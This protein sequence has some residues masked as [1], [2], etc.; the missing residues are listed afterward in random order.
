MPRWGSK[1]Q[2]EEP[3]KQSPTV[4][5]LR[6]AWDGKLYTE[7]Q[8]KEHYGG[9]GGADIWK[10]QEPTA[11]FTSSPRW[12]HNEG[13]DTPALVP[14]TS[15]PRLRHNEGSEMPAQ[16]PVPPQ[17]CIQQRRRHSPSQE[18]TLH[19][20]DSDVAEPP[21]LAREA[22]IQPHHPDVVQ[23]DETIYT[24]KRKGC[25]LFFRFYKFQSYCCSGCRNDQGHSKNCDKRIVR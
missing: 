11:E 6:R 21:P 23:D 22:Y 16:P 20:G 12:R 18:P 10:E 24:C 25:G 4:E 3:Q 13:S 1:A 15:S 5:E 8:F 14:S 17:P 7:N 9:R 2:R 19:S